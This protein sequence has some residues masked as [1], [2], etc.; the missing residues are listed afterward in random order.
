M[1]SKKLF[2]FLFMS[3]MF[4]LTY[5]Q[6]D[7]MEMDKTGGVQYTPN[8]KSEFG[9]KLGVPVVSGDFETDFS[10]GVGINFR[11]ALDYIFSVRGGLYYNA[12][13]GE[14]TDSPRTTRG[15][16]TMTD[17]ENNTFGADLEVL[18]SL[19]NMR[20][21]RPAGEKKV[22]VYVGGGIGYVN[23]DLTL[24]QQ[25]GNEI[26]D[27]LE[28]PAVN[29]GNN[30]P[31][32]LGSTGI[33]FKISDNVNLAVDYQARLPFGGLSDLIDGY[34]HLNAR[35]TTFRDVIHFA[36]I[37]LNFGFG[38]GEGASA[39]L[40]WSNPMEQVIT[41][42]QELQARPVLDLTDTDGDGIIDMMDQEN[43]SP[44]GA[45]VDTRGVTLDSDGDGV[46][47]YK[48]KEPYSMPGYSVDQ[49][50]VA[51]VP[52]PGYVTEAQVNA[53]ID[54]K[55]AGFKGGGGTLSDWFLPMIH[56]NL[57]SYSIRP[58]DYGHMAN[59]AHVMKANPDVRVVVKGFTD[60]LGSD[61]YNQ[62]LSYNRAKSAVEFLANRYGISR[63]RLILTYGGENMKLVPEA[64]GG[65][66][67]N[68]RVE[69]MVSDGTETEMGRPDGPN[70][71]KGTF[72]ASRA[73]GY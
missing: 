70:A 10:Y 47:D 5:A 49:D 56:F 15:N 21:T 43:D 19:N 59:I 39:P 32:L 7:M 16:V 20:W 54:G 36:G 51:Q 33:A 62:V 57:D 23:M 6:D 58:A 46:P 2:L 45:L 48:D 25:N 14:E 13:R 22:D 3:C 63:D 30:S 37:G 40:Y 28:S 41:D 73:A 11:R 42:I 1:T 66:F 64:N 69:F 53:L 72:G 24:I 12:L 50:G 71:G 17:F 68:R 65:S 67:M 8:H 9:I 60:N 34:D 18:I 27:F 55:L 26:E 61:R 52:N 35:I 29:R 44:A 38:G 4:T 31:A